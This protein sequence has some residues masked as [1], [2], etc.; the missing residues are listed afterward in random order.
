ME[1]LH[2]IGK[3]IPLKEWI[4]LNYVLHIPDLLLLSIMLVEDS[5]AVN[6]CMCKYQV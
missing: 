1:R 6:E 5:S 4:N 2:F 3:V